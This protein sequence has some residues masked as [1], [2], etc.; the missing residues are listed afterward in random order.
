[1]AQREQDGISLPFPYS[2]KTAIKSS[3]LEI[4]ELKLFF[5]FFKFSKLF[6]KM[7]NYFIFIHN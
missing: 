6:S 1:M 3:R 4:L 2:V 7:L 5:F